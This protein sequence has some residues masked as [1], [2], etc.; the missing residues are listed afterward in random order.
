[1]TV[2][3]D[4]IMYHPSDVGRAH[5]Q[6]LPYFGK[7]KVEAEKKA[8]AEMPGF[9]V[10]YSEIS[11]YQP[12]SRLNVTDLDNDFIK[13]D[14]VWKNSMSYI[15]EQKLKPVPVGTSVSNERSDFGRYRRDYYPSRTRERHGFDGVS[16]DR[17][18]DD[19]L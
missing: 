3:Y 1:M 12:L 19:E 7:D 5:P 15:E 16:A 17:L 6:V 4:V 10:A 18:I 2:M 9:I 8:L 13:I 11:K 14:G